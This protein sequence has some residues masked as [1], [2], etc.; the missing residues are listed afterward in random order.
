M[1]YSDKI[2]DITARPDVRGRCYTGLEVMAIAGAAS[3]IAGIG[4]G[5][6]GA[7]QQS[8]AQRQAGEIAYQ[9][10]LI[11]N[12]QMEAE[13]KRLENEAKQREDNANAQ[14]AAKQREAIEKKR[15]AGIAASRAQAVMAA[16]GA[17]VDTNLIDGI[18]GEGQLA[19]DTAIYEGESKA[20]DTRY[21][22]TLN[23]HE[24]ETRRWQG[25]TE[26]MQGGRTRDAMN[27][28]A[29]NTMT[30][31]IVKG[32]VGATSLASKYAPDFGGGIT[33]ADPESTMAAYHRTPYATRNPGFE[34]YGP[35]FDI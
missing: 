10:A 7:S 5:I 13:A 1:I 30:M 9:N 27:R 21:Q 29:D 18:L 26:L 17:G 2:A 16:S 6:I 4:M 35:E 25:R 33:A 31:G 24:A 32:V 14:E 12:Q 3:S 15:E 20:Q 28:R 34:D 8:D 11:R 23:R 19:F 22:A